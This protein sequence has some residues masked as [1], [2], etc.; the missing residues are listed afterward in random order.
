MAYA[1]FDYTKPDPSVDNGTAAFTN[2]RTNLLALRDALIVGIMPGWSMTPKN[3][4]EDGPP[5]DYSQPPKILYVK[6][7][8]QVRA[9]I[10]WSSNLP[11]ST[12][13]EYSADSGSTYVTIGTESYAYD[14]NDNCTGVTW[15]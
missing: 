14:S 7:T 4:A 13:Y 10:T 15:A 3:S 6:G 12:Q 9:T 8:E 5:S 1:A 11:S 2:T